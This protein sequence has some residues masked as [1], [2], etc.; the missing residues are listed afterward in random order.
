MREIH[1]LCVKILRALAFSQCST[2]ENIGVLLKFRL[3]LALLH[4]LV[5]SV[6][7]LHGS[8]MLCGLSRSKTKQN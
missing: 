8:F 1:A 2:L 5:I 4:E 6:D 3:A 7:L